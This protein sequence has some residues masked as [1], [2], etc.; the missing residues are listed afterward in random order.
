MA[1]IS[2]DGRAAEPSLIQVGAQLGNPMLRQMC[3]GNLNFLLVGCFID[4]LSALG[5]SEL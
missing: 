3:S 5:D 1:K 2:L 4:D